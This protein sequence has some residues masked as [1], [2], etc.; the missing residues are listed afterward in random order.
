MRTLLCTLFL[1]ACL[2]AAGSARAETIRL[3]L[4]DH[5]ILVNGDG[6]AGKEVRIAQRTERVPGRAGLAFG[7]V[8]RLSGGKA[9]EPVPY[10]T[11][12]NF[13][14]AQ[15]VP[16]D[17]APRIH[18]AKTRHGRFD[19]DQALWHR[20]SAEEAAVPGQW[21]LRVSQGGRLLLEKL[22]QLDPQ[23]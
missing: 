7:V 8:F 12:I 21:V 23:P 1:A 10:Q 17:G 13:R 5:G 20:L 14:R 18:I 9:G 3:E 4:V 2:V 11:E 22:F 19:E 16:Q 6:L 15:G